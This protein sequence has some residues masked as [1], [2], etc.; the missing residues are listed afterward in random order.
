MMHALNDLAFQVTAG[1]MKTE[2]EKLVS[3][4]TAQ[5]TQTHQL[6]TTQVT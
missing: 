2:E 3:S 4:T 5:Q 6:P 1:T